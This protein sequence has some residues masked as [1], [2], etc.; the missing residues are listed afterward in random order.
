M[1][2]LVAGW[3]TPGGRPV[4]AGVHGFWCATAVYMVIVCTII[5]VRSVPGDN[6]NIFQALHIQQYE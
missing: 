3:L 5:G 6:A 4:E 2:G 1:G